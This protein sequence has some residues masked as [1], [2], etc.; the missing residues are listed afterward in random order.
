MLAL[1][2]AMRAGMLVLEVPLRRGGTTRAWRS[3]A[4]AWALVAV[5]TGITAWRGFPQPGRMGIATVGADMF[6]SATA[7]AVRSLGAP[8]EF[9]WTAGAAYWSAAAVGGAVRGPVRQA[10]AVTPLAAAYVGVRLR[11]AGAAVRGMRV[12]QDFLL[13]YVFAVGVGEVIRR[14]R[15]AAVEIESE[16]EQAVRSA[17]AATRL[18]EEYRARRELHVGAVDALEAI[19]ERWGGD[20]DGA[21][22]VAATEARR[23]RAWLDR[24]STARAVGRTADLLERIDEVADESQARG[25][26]V[27]LITVE[28]G[29]VAS[30]GAASALVDAVRVAVERAGRP[31]DRILVRLASDDDGLRVTARSRGDNPV[32]WDG[33]ISAVSDAVEACGGQVA[34]VGGRLEIG[35]PP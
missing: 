28:L 16:A 4:S 29:E 33:V 1:L 20:A 26:H 21:R 15:L 32:R 31:G 12:I 35:F 22:R 25:I 10:A 3:T 6:A 14:M 13:F 7:V 9:D 34:L 17:A 2:L 5:S 11:N 18:E 27:E 30:P 19:R 24:E 8:D 23:I